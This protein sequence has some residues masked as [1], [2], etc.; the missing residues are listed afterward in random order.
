M[1]CI[2]GMMQY[3]QILGQPLWLHLCSISNGVVRT[4]SAWDPVR[5]W[6]VAVEFFRD[7]WLEVQAGWDLFDGGGRMGIE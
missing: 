6:V 2:E 7:I 1:L 5:G 3:A 4:G